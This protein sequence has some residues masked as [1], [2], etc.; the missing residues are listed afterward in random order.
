MNKEFLDKLDALESLAKLA[1]PGDWQVTEKDIA[2]YNM[3]EENETSYAKSV[4]NGSIEVFDPDSYVNAHYIAYANPDFIRQMISE[5][6]RL[7]KENEN[8]QGCYN[9][10]QAWF[11]RLGCCRCPQGVLSID[12]KTSKKML[13]VWA[14][15]RKKAM[16]EDCE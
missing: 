15:A 4:I 13:E 9:S 6:R 1:S 5:L 7:A 8:L 3:G 14:N 2:V 12:D 10:L 11:R 16:E